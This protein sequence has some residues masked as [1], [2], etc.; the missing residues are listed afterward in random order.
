MLRPFHR[1]WNGRDTSYGTTVPKA[2]LIPFLLVFLF[3][4]LRQV[5]KY[6]LEVE[7]VERGGGGEET[8]DG[9]LNG[10]EMLTG[11]EVDVGTVSVEGYACEVL[12]R[13]RHELGQEMDILVLKQTAEIVQTGIRSG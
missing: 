11:I 1:A 5:V 13:R 10:V 3:L 12:L 4:K 9:G 2:V 8:G 7:G 6:T